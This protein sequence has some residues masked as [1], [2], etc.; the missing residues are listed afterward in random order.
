[1]QKEHIKAYTG[2]RG[3]AA[4]TLVLSHIHLEDI[5]PRGSFGSLDPLTIIMNIFSAWN[6]VDVFF[7]LS[8]FILGYVYVSDVNNSTINYKD[9]LVKRIAR[10]VP[11]HYLTILAIGLMAVIAQY[12][13]IP[14][15]G[16]HLNEIPQQLLMVHAWPYFL[17]SPWNG[18]SWYVSISFFAYLF[19]MPLLPK[20]VS[21][22]KKNYLLISFSFLVLGMVWAL[23][24]TNTLTDG[25]GWPAINRVVCQFSIGYL[26]YSLTT[27]KNPVSQ[28]ASKLVSVWLLL[29]I[30]WIN[31][32]WPLS[33]V[34]QGIHNEF[35]Q[36]IS[37]MLFQFVF[38]LLILGLADNKKS[39]AKT[40]LANRFFLWLGAMSYSLY[41]FHNV[42][43][44]VIHPF[45]D[46]IPDSTWIRILISIG[47]YAFVLAASW[48]VYKFIEVQSR[49]Y[50]IK[51]F[52][53]SKI[54]N[55]CEDST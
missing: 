21:K 20:F 8:G 37:R 30:V 48:S 50:V 31:S 3:I 13:G 4:A 2:I 32:R 10:I 22:M 34:W 35:P 39:L 41:M 1:M 27:F 26:L 24:M 38:A 18:P 29:A 11:L 7:I 54:S 44:K 42:I 23:T 45:V 49:N 40:I 9:F 51:F 6:Q 17:V 28:V 15:R 16:Y 43:G 55:K 25:Y 33:M 53:K 52:S 14:N 36:M 5:M 12:F 19:L 46:K 47:L